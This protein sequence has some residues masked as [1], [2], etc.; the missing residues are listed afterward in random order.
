VKSQRN[1]KSKTVHHQ[2][3]IE[4]VEIHGEITDRMRASYDRFWQLLIGR[5]LN[6]GKLKPQRRKQTTKNKKHTLT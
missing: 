6:E 2:P 1:K 5:L 4:M 3:V